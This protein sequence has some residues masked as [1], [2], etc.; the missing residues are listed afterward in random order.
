MGSLKCLFLIKGELQ[1]K[2]TQDFLED[3]QENLIKLVKVKNLAAE[4]LQTQNACKLV[5]KTYS[6]LL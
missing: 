2:V 6:S 4:C 5:M 3:T 1:W